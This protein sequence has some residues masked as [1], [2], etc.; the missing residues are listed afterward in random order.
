MITHDDLVQ[1]TPEW[2][3]HRREHFNASDAPAMM[4]CSPYMTRTE[5]LHQMH[6]GLAKEVDPDTQARFDAGHRAEALARPLAAEI[7]GE[8]LYPVTGSEGKLSA[9]FDGLNMPEDVGFEHKSINADLRNLQHFVGQELPLMYRVQMEQQLMVAGAEK[10]LFMASKWNGDTLVEE[11]HCWYAPDLELRAKI[12]AGWHQFEADLAAYTPTAP[13]VQ[14][15]AAP[16]ESLP[17]VSVR[18]DGQLVVASNLPE[19]A[20]ALRAF[21]ER[22]PAKPST[23]QEFADCE[24]ACKSLK[25]A[26]DALESAETHALAQMTDVEQM[27]RIVADLRNLA[28]A[29]RLAS[30]KTV[31]AR[32][33]SIRLEIVQEGIA[34]I[35]QHITALNTRLGKPYM[36]AVPADFAGAI[37]G[38]RT[39]DSLRDAVSTT[40]ANAKIAA[41]ATADKIQANLTTLRELAKDHAFL[42]ADTA[43]LVL[44]DTDTV[45]N[46]I[47]I[48]IMDHKAAK[49]AEE[50][51]TRARIAEQ[52]RIKAEAAANAKAAAELATAREA[53]RIAAAKAQAEK[54]A[55]DAITAAQATL[56]PAPA[57][58]QPVPTTVAVRQVVQP[59][60]PTS[61]PTLT[62]GMMSNRLGFQLTAAFITSLGFE[63]AARVKTSVLYHEHQFN[64][65]CQALIDHISSVCSLQA[66]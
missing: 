41:S 38:K 46:I 30:E 65:I 28:R 25:K 26:E 39:V 36:P 63:P 17:A 54:Q 40:L 64:D 27:R 62:L 7:I 49:A 6:T 66:A 61:P 31:A 56:V 15:V 3:A 20:T 13:T 33:E 35:G 11:R 9:S 45:E 16:V 5:L 60:R 34:A 24:A 55:Q 2:L 32:K 51:A 53:D 47:K 8:D 59:I 42:F 10:I 58:A 43:Q 1:G 14:A 50:E 37:K 4:G 57:P 21:I 22:I 29:T 48:R 12:I 23:D 18:L 44:K 52:E 19:F